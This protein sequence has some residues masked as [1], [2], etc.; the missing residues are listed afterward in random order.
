MSE[1]LACFKANDI[2]GTFPHPL[3]SDLAYA[4]GTVLAKHCA[5]KKA[6]IAQ[7]IRLSG[8]KLRSAIALGLHENGCQVSFL[9]LSG[10][11][12][13]YYAA[14]HG[15]Y[16]CGIMITGSH[17]PAEENGFKLVR[18]GAIP[19]SSESGLFSIRDH[20]DRL[21]Q[22]L[23]APSADFPYAEPAKDDAYL[24]WLL[25]SSG[26]EHAKIPSRP[27]KVLAC[28]GNGCAGPLLARLA[29]FLPF[30]LI[31][32]Y[33][34]PDG[35]FPHGVPNPLLPERRKDTQ[36]AVLAA[37]ADLGV[38]FDGD[39]DRCF[40]F[41]AKGQFIEGYYLV[42]LLAH[43]ILRT[44]PGAKIVHDPRLYWHTQ[45]VVRKA[46]G[47]P[48]LCRAGHAMIK[49]CM[50]REDAV[51]GGEMSAHHYFRDFNYCDCGMLPFLLVSSLLLQSSQ[52]LEEM[53]AQAM[54]RYPCSGEINRKVSDPQRVLTH[55]RSLYAAHS[56]H[57]DHLDGLSLTFSTWRFN[58]RMSNTEPLLR[59]N[60]ESRGDR[61]LMEDKTQ[62]ILVQIDRYAE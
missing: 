41:D 58:V 36:E 44:H 40:F 11:E 20:V 30:E 24:H 21:L 28:A 1:A 59:L 27:F 39:F 38:A 25:Q 42:G 6:L 12:E 18:R 37:H 48:I 5:V 23:K 19:I 60:V 49:A 45:E 22:T 53:V 57:E 16:D 54:A 29:P 15:D 55:L 8:P 35:T 56:L 13:V 14:T 43:E 2:R 9:G 3:S 61:A 51:Y 4:L 10:T 31:I 7:D 50:R 62:E 34:E 32:Q 47:I 52:T 26:F 17:N 33:G 46:H